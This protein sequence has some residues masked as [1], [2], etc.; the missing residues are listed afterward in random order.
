MKGQQVGEEKYTGGMGNREAKRNKVPDG[1]WRW[2]CLPS[3]KA[4]GCT[5]PCEEV[6]GGESGTPSWLPYHLTPFQ[7]LSALHRSWK[8]IV[9]DQQISFQYKYRT[10]YCAGAS[11]G[12]FLAKVE[13]LWLV[14]ANWE[15]I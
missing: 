10:C 6:E 13:N 2:V 8:Q 3:V 5:V 1:V 12:S 14:L 15:L 4:E 7:D 9:A 11:F